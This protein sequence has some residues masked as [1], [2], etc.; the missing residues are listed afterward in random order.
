VADRLNYR[1]QV[2]SKDFQAVHQFKVDGWEAAQ[3]NM[4]PYVAVDAK[5]GRVYV[6][7]PTKNKVH[8]YTLDGKDHK[9]YDKG[10]DGAAP[11]PFN[12]PTGLAVAADGTVYVGD[13]GSGRILTLKP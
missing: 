4:E 13:S 1:I 11:A 12:L 8:S 2:I 7:D 9:A 5:R 10:M 6:S 3:I